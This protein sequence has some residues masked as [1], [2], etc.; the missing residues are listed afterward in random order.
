MPLTIW[1]CVFVNLILIECEIAIFTVV[2]QE[3]RLYFLYP[4][5]SLHIFS[6]LSLILTIQSAVKKSINVDRPTGPALTGISLF[7]GIYLF[8]DISSQ[9]DRNRTRLAVNMRL[10]G[11]RES[12]EASF[13]S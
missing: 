4:A 11:K 5:F 6:I 9:V 2:Q 13:L 10:P 3:Q 1:H 7:T 12:Q 8:S